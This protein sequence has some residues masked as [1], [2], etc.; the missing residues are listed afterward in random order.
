MAKKLVILSGPSCVGKGPLRAALKRCHP[1]ITFGEPILCH[2]RTPRFSRRT[3]SY[4]VHGK[5]Y[6]FLP[7]GLFEQMDPRYFL[8]VKI[9]TEY[10][11]ID[12]VQLEYILETN[13]LVLIEAYTTLAGELIQWAK[14]QKEIELNI[15]TV[16]LTPLSNAE[17]EERA[18]K[19][20]STP[21]QIVYEVMKGKLLRR[22]ED[23]PDKIEVRAKCA[24]WEIQQS[25]DYDFHIVNHAGED[26]L[27]E[28]GDPPGPEASR[29][30]AEFVQ[31]LQS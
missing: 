9:R 11:A 13:D 6:Y 14:K 26:D 27:D 16:F 8:T 22:N 20:K 1:E 29:V 10:Q 12:L 28:W 18:G 25:G 5:D 7:R 15:K 2:S 24:Y 3:G 23:P 31:I 21:E 17:I 19:E 4:E 30:L